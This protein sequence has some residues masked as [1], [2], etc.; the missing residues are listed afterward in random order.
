MMSRTQFLM[1]F[2][3]GGGGAAYVYGEALT[4]HTGQERAAT[5]AP[6]IGRGSGQHCTCSF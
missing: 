6:D 1:V 2:S 5:G 3:R 4:Q